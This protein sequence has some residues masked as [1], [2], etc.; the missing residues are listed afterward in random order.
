MH[1]ESHATEVV[2]RF[3]KMLS[4]EAME[5]IEEDHFAELE[6]LVAAAL[7]VIDSQAKHD[8]AKKVEALAHELRVGSSN[9][10]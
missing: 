4:Q 8:F 1:Y 3:K 9:A 6:T 7:G 2:N 5:V 10:D